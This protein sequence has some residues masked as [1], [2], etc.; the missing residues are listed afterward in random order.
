MI[1]QPTPDYSNLS[2]STVASHCQHTQEYRT[3][4]GE[5]LGSWIEVSME[6]KTVISCRGCGI[7]FQK[8]VEGVQ[9]EMLRAYQEQMR[10]LACPGC[11]EEPF[12]G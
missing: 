12:L 8:F 7:E 3:E 2:Q 5:L 4:S 6:S 10:R 1:H 9:A 11:G